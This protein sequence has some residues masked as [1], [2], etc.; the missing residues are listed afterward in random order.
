MYAV[1]LA[2]G[3]G[4]RLWPRSR[5]NRP[6]Q[7]SDITGSGF[8]M[9][10]ETAQRLE[11]LIDSTRLFVVTGPA[12]ADLVKE[13][14]PQISMRQLIIE[15]SGRNTAPAIGLASLY[16]RREDPG[17]V[18]AILP[19]DH[20]ILHADRFRA[21]LRRAADVAQK[22]FLVTLG[23]EPTFAHTG[24]GYIKRG[25][26]LSTVEGIPAY[27]VERFLEK[28]NRAAAEQFLAE[29]GYYWNG[30]IFVSRVDTMLNEFARQAPEIYKRLEQ[31]D[32]A[33]DTPEAQKVLESVWQE[34]PSISIDYAVMEGAQ[35]VAM[36]P[37]KAGWNDVGSWDALETVLE[38]DESGNR[39]ARGEVLLLDSHDNIVYSD[40]RLVALINVNNLVV[41]D[42]GDTLLIGDKGNM[43]RVK[44]VVE[45]LRA[46]GRT[47]LL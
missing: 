32:A 47:E 6:K 13:Q 20:V 26:L 14:L 19:A 8:T 10:Q 28:P 12:Y 1:I 42:T 36:V 5:E 37:L 41:V 46:Q 27:R 44:E 34:M 38:Q 31:I 39:I 17:A 24:Y 16:L 23:I 43:Q 7:F 33:L 22:G 29:G 25:E 40:K 4:T 9:I 15:P 30:G 18:M 3:V 2:G 45:Q 35:K 11:G 21:A